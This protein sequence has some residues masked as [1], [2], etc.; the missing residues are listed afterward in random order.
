MKCR[1]LDVINVGE[2]M[3]LEFVD[4]LMKSD[5]MGMKRD[6]LWSD[7][8]QRVFTLLPS[9]RPYITRDFDEV[10]DNVSFEFCKK[11]VLS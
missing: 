10:A 8:S 3:L 1:W 9:T 2:D 5:D 4:K 11:P 6:A 7:F